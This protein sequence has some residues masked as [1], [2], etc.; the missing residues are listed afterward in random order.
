MNFRLK[1][2]F[3][4]HI[5]ETQWYN[6]CSLRVGLGQVRLYEPENLVALREILQEIDSPPLIVARGSNLIG[7]DNLTIMPVLRLP[8]SSEFAVVEQLDVCTFRLGAALGLL[9]AARILAA[10]GC[11][12][13]APLAGIPGSLGGALA[14]NAGANGQEISSL[15][16]EMRGWDLRLDRPWHW[17]R[18]QGGWGYRQSP[19]AK[20]VL[21]LEAVLELYPVQTE[22]E[23]ALIL[24]ELNR[25]SLTNPKGASAGS[26]FRNPSRGN[27]A[28]RLLEQ[29]GCK[30]LSH[31]SFQV[32]QK[33]ANWII[34]VGGKPGKAEDCRLLVNDMKKRVLDQSGLRL[35][36]EWKWADDA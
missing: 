32:S 23:T 13:L 5:S 30:G 17:F 1:S 10:R 25:R 12:G 8:K 35:H 6:L 34:N 2:G 19:I 24:A 28:G 22:D 33:H 27:P 31:G 7:A 11:G 20:D 21:I 16:R 15:V 9:E 26:V 4:M 18:E 29:A 36:C 3:Y 14:M